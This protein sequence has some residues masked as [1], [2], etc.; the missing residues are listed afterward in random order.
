MTE[1]QV[2][3]NGDH[4]EYERE[5]AGVPKEQRS[6]WPLT[7]FDAM[8]WAKEFNKRHPSVSVEDA[9]AWFAPALMCG[10]DE[11]NRRS[12]QSSASDERYTRSEVM[13]FIGWLSADFKELHKTHPEALAQSFDRFLKSTRNTRN[14]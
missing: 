13:Q 8:D 6:D 12:A 10:F 4:F 5:N 14:V 2:I 7:S 1:A 11:A 9:L 3:H